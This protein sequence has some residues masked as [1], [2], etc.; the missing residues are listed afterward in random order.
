MK[1]PNGELVVIREYDC[2]C[3]VYLDESRHEYEE[4]G[5]WC[6]GASP[7]HGRL[8]THG[9]ETQRDRYGAPS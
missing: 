9:H 2:G 6:N 3:R 5:L 1:M 8:L 7:D 4:F